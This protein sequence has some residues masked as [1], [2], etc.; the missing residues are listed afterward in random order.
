MLCEGGSHSSHCGLGPGHLRARSLNRY[1]RCLHLGTRASGPHCAPRTL[2]RSLSNSCCG[3]M[4]CAAKGCERARRRWAASDRFHAQ[5]LAPGRLALTFARG[6]LGFGGGHRRL[7]LNDAGRALPS[8][9]AFSVS[10]CIRASTWPA[11]EVA[12][13]SQHFQQPPTFSSSNVNL[14]G[15]NAAI[16]TG[17]AFRGL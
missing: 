16:A 7:R 6:H 5:P 15:F 11:C 10:T 8:R 17:K 9:W 13:F 4:P 12:L 1:L 3:H 14:S 2:A